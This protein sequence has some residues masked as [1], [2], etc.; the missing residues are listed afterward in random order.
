[1]WYGPNNLVLC[2]TLFYFNQSPIFFIKNLGSISV[3]LFYKN[4]YVLFKGNENIKLMSVLLRSVI[5]FFSKF[6]YKYFFLISSYLSVILKVLFIFLFSK[7]KFQGKG[8]YLYKNKRLSLG[9]Q[10]NYSHK[11]NLYI[12][13]SLIKNFSKR[14]WIF[15]GLNI[16]EVLFFL[17]GFKSRRPINVFT[18]RGI[19]FT[20]QII[21]KKNR[22]N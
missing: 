5:L 3:V 14:S 15:F 11:L 8:Y 17:K 19:R 22:K 13:S 9:L 10:F 21:Y 1:M 6:T 2:E 4:Y 7:I 18:L 12:N 16:R 20:K